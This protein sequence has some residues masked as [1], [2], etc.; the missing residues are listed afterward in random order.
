MQKLALRL[1]IPGEL[2]KL[3]KDRGVV[4]FPG[5]RVVWIS[6]HDQQHEFH[7]EHST[8]SALNARARNPGKRLAHPLHFP[9]LANFNMEEWR[10]FPGPLDRLC[11]GHKIPQVVA[12]DRLLGLRKRAIDDDSLAVA[13]DLDGFGL[14]IR[15][16]TR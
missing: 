2:L 4:G 13:A 3:C 14:C 5:W 10:K 1:Q 12:T 8:H 16:Q 11:F 6:V 15:T 9:D 7:R